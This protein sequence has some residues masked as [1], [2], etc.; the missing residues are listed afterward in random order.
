M[1]SFSEAFRHAGAPLANPL[2]NWSA[3]APDRSF[4]AITIWEHEWKRFSD[5]QPLLGPTVEGTYRYFR[6]T[7]EYLTEWN[8]NR[9]AAGRPP[10]DSSV[11]WRLMKE[12][13]GEAFT[14]KLPVRIIFI[15]PPPGQAPDGAERAQVNNANYNDRWSCAVSFF[16]PATGAYEIAVRPA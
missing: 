10:A 15:W 4:I 6:N 12:H 16:D 1:P 2:N 13:L 9:V 11:G 7:P 8:A 5:K 3:I 14:R